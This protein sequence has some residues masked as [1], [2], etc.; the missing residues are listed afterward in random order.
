MPIASL[1]K[2][3]TALIIAERIRPDER[4]PI[5]RNAAHTAG[6]DDRRAAAWASKV[7]SSRC[8]T[9]LIMVSAN[10][11]AVA[12][13]E[14]DGGHGPALRQAD[15]PPGARDGPLLHALLHART[16]CETAATTPARAT[17]PRSPAPTWPNPR[18]AR[19]A[20]TRYAK[21]RFPIRGKHLYLANNHYF[22]QHGLAGLPGAQVTG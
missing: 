12:L 15:E 6:L 9:A 1:T 7:R 17:W 20:Q 14:H 13:A 22:L 3:M 5:S 4:V 21:P 18:I 2:M 8:S 16:G 19:I 10:D 11:A